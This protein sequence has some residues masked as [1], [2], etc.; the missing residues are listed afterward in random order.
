MKK[1]KQSFKVLS[2]ILVVLVCLL[3]AAFVVS[4]AGDPVFSVVST[5]GAPGDTITVTISVSGNPGIAG[6]SAELN[7]DKSV[8]TPTGVSAGNVL[9]RKEIISNFDAPEFD[10]NKADSL[11][12]MFY[13]AT[14][15][16]GNGAFFVVTFKVKDGVKPSTSLLEFI[17]DDASNQSQGVYDIAD[18]VGRVSI[19]EAEEEEEKDDDKTDEKP[20]AEIKLR[21]KANKIKYMAGRSNGKF[22]PDENATRYEVVECFYNLFDVDVMV[23]NSKS[24]K[25]VSTK[26]NS[27]VNLF[28]AA[29]VVKGYD[30]G[31]FKG[32][33]TITRAEFCVLIVNLM[34]LDISKARDQGFPDVKG[35]NWY[36]PYVNACAKA[37]YV[38][39]RD[40]GMFDPNGLI[41]RAEVA[42][43]INRITK[44][45]VEAAT[46]CIYS[47]VSPKKWYFKQVAAAAK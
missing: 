42:T 30:D 35:N 12:F 17:C 14:N 3:C 40:T 39:G 11:T 32:D 38:K 36:V 33:N 20:L 47:D 45:N 27:M 5:E 37:G 41:T 29:G 22:E 43:L 6:M 4:A 13:G 10:A 31:T 28:A 21:N 46:S 44:V 9:S 19:I 23:N 8:L 16:T 15:V 18:V 34:G 26:Y 25:D 24:F 2:T 1:I 7:F